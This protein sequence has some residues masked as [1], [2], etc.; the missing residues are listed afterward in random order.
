M[1]WPPLL[2]SPCLAESPW[3]EPAG[4]ASAFGR[5][6]QRN[7][8]GRSTVRVPEERPISAPWASATVCRNV[9]RKVFRCSR[10]RSSGVGACGAAE[11]AAGAG[12]TAP[13]ATC[14][15]TMARAVT[16]AASAALSA[17]NPVGT[18]FNMLCLSVLGRRGRQHFARAVRLQRPDESRDLHRL[19]EPRGAVVPDLEPPL[20]GGDR[21][22]P[23]RAAPRGDGDRGTRRAAAGERLARSA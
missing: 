23:R 10:Y 4:A 5:I 20:Y 22:P 11:A 16:P 17:G 3:D 6:S 2:A 7:F 1:T 9:T 19:Q 12:C 13:W 8:P 14:T 21:V 15:A 18:R